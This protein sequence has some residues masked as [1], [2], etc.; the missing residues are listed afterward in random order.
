MPE[1]QKKPKVPHSIIL[2]DRK[3][4]TMSGIVDVGSFDEHEVS[5]YTEIGDLCIKGDNLH[6]SKIN[7]EYG[8]LTLDGEINSMIY[9]ENRPQSQGFFSKLFK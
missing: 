8:D 7:L 9:S 4:L 1:D 2:K 6:I 3:C 5:V